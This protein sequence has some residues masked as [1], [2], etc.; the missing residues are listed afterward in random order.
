MKNV[1]LIGIGGIGMSALA[2]YYN[3]FGYSVS[4]YDSTASKL[5]LELEAEGIEVHYD[6]NIN[7]IPKDKDSTLVIYTP[8]VPETMSELYFVLNNGYQVVKRSKALGHIAKEHKCLAIAGTHGKTTTSTMLAHIYRASSVGCNAFLGGIAKNYHSNLFLSK[9]EILVAEADEFDRSFLQ[10]FPHSAA[11]TAIDADH[12]D[13][14]GSLESIRESFHAFT[15]Q[16]SANIVINKD[17]EN[18]AE[19][20]MG[21]SAKFYT[22]AVGKEADFYAKDIVYASEG[23][24]TFTFVTPQGQIENCYLGLPGIINVMNS[25][26]ASALAYLNG[27]SLE[28]IRDAL[29][30][31]VGVERRL[32]LRV[33]NETHIYI[34]DYAHHPEEINATLKSV[35]KLYPDK[36]ICAIF[37]PH[38]FSRT[39]DFYME[40]AESLSHIDKVIL[41]PIYPAREKPIEGVTSKLI[42]DNIRIKDKFLFD[43]EE[44]LSEV[45]NMEFDILL[46]LGAGDIDRLVEPIT[47]LLN[48]QEEKKC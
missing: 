36:I 45:K 25:V 13:I 3:H 31:F 35:R 17:I 6:D 2:R 28:Q 18:I 48:E 16:V 27:I 43:K 11:I 21:S 26:A 39:S 46:T 9:S 40:F 32:D 8:A 1:Y 30:S 47:N 33:N 42:L 44:V 34:D 41:L 24:I 12:L 15:K 7:Y 19:L 20:Q 5:T 29:S 38:L 4:G 23:R 22:Y 10:L 14:Y 37:Q